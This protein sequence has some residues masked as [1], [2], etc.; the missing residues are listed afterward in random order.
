MNS[1][2][3]ILFITLTLI[4]LL[5]LPS[6]F[7]P[8]WHRDEGIS[9][10]VGQTIANGAVLY[11]DVF[12]NKMP[13]FYALFALANNIFNVKV[14]GL[15]FSIIGA[16][17]FVLLTHKVTKNLNAT[18]AAGIIYALLTSL[19]L[20][21]GNVIN[22]EILMIVP[23]IIGMYMLFGK[24]SI[25]RKRA[26][27]AG[28]FFGLA[29][30]IKAPSLFDAAAAGI[31]ILL[32]TLNSLKTKVKILTLLGLGFLIPLA[33]AIMYFLFQNALN[34]FIDTAFLGN[35]GYVDWGTTLII[36]KG[37][38]YARAIMVTALVAV[39]FYY[40]S[41]MTM[42]TKI[43]AVWFLFAAYGALLSGRPY[44]HYLLQIAPSVALTAGLIVRNHSSLTSVLILFTSL[45]LSTQ[46]FTVNLGSISYQKDYYLNAILW[47]TGNKTTKDYY[48][49]FEPITARNYEINKYLNT[50]L[51]PN[52]KIYIW[53]DEPT[54]Y[55]LSHRMPVGRYVASYHTDM[56][57]NLNSYNDTI[58]KLQEE[59]PRI[60]LMI[61]P[62][63]R[64]FPELDNLLEG[65]YN[66]ATVIEDVEIYGRKTGL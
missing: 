9:L 24:D 47:A 40:R 44:T 42:A 36:P 50:H 51:S 4:I 11:R 21:E 49:F 53:G 17:F 29:F 33:I 1:I 16:I 8:L 18:A 37:W 61:K 12:D 64:P 41:K 32:F 20:W 66:K 60:I 59:K 57:R 14:V 38:L 65:Y 34:D 26:L 19:P 25:T 13:L 30:M 2:K 22:G 23:T 46:V 15:L 3:K 5:R 7:E 35:T 63:P 28:I 10:T 48:N 54:I 55:A 56:N 52:E 62:Q 58:K 43:A 6:L 39:L 31:L 27:V 45:V